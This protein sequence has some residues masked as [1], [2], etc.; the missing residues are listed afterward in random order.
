M[1][2]EQKQQDLT[3]KGR[4]H[5]TVTG[6]TEVVSFDETAVMLKTQLGDL[7]VLGQGLQLRELSVAGGQTCV[8]GEI[9]ALS[10]EEPRQGGWLRRLMG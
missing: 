2:E 7:T 10:Y 9:S 1:V 4:R 8:E 3:L 5:L 6:V